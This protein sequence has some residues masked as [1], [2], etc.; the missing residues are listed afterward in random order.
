V[1]VLEYAERI[2]LYDGREHLCGYPLPAEFVRN[3][4][5]SPEGMPAPRHGPRNRKRPTVEEETRLRELA[6][7]VGAFLDRALAPR[8]IQRH[9]FVRF[10]DLVAELYASI[11]DH[12]QEKVLRHYAKYDCLLVDEVGYI[13]VEPTQAG[14]F[15]TLMQKRHKKR[16]TIITSNLG[17]SDWGTFLKNPHLT[18]ALIDR[19]TETSYVINMGECEGLREPPP[20]ERKPGDR[21]KGRA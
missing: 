11:A 6:P 16:T 4:R 12:T 20:G 5:F 17:F 14:M 8:G 13:E 18:A 2:A 9:R 10:A 3:T 1:T 7:A 21:R 15:F 19:F